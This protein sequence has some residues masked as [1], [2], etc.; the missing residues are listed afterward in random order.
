MFLVKSN[1]EKLLSVELSEKRAITTQIVQCIQLKISETN[2]NNRR[3]L[4]ACKF[5]SGLNNRF[6]YVRL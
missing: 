6:C 1:M 3:P 5:F 2:R 4:R